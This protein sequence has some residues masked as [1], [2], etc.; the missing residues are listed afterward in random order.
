MLLSTTVQRDSQPKSERREMS[1]TCL[2]GNSLT[3]RYI[4]TMRYQG[5]NNIYIM[6]VYNII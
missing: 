5:H 3:Y 6:F 2:Q 4:D 1:T